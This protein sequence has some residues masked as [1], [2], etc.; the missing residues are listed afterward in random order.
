MTEDEISIKSEFETLEVIPR[1]L[2]LFG[3]PMGVNSISIQTSNMFG[4]GLI[5]YIGAVNVMDELLGSV[6]TYET[7]GMF[8]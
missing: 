4:G 8:R 2:V 7:L 5:N 1:V 6:Y 3:A